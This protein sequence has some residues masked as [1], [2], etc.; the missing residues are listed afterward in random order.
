M[1]NTYAVCEEERLPLNGF[2]GVQISQEQSA[3]DNSAQKFQMVYNEN[4]DKAQ[5]FS[6]TKGSAATEMNAGIRVSA[7]VHSFYALL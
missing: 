3:N 5:S 7:R 1:R 2:T 4:S 6:V